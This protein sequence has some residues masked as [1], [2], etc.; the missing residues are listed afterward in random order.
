MFE[1]QICNNYY[2]HCILADI[3]ARTMKGEEQYPIHFAAKYNSMDALELLLQKG[4][5]PDVLDG[6]LRTPLHVVAEQGF[7]I[8]IY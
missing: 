4:A 1:I 6:R 8:Y 3:R 5:K 2:F 7:Y